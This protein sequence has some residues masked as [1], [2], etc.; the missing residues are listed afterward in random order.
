LE[1]SLVLPD[2]GLQHQQSM[3]IRGS[4]IWFVAISAVLIALVLWFGKKQ[5]VAT[6]AETSVA[7]PA[8]AAPSAPATVPVHTNAPMVQT[9]KGAG[10]SQSPP[11]SKVERAIGILSTYND[12][13]IVFYGRVEDQFTNAV[14]DATVSFNV[15]VMNGQESTVN[16]GQVMTDGNGFFIILGY[17]GQDLGLVPHKPGYVLATTDTLFKYSHLEEHPYV[18]DP[19]NPTVIKMWKLQ[20]AEPLVGIDK[21]Y[22]LRYT[23]EPINFDLLAGQIVPSGGD[24]QITLNRPAGIIS[25]RNPQNW[26]IQI[27]VIDGGFIVTSW[28]EAQTTYSAPESGYESSG[29]F[30]NNN[31]IDTLDQMLF[32]QSR[33]GQVYSKIHLVLGINQ[34]PDG[35][36]YITFKGVA[37]ANGSRNW[38]ATAPQ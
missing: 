24:I 35:F 12:I 1:Y 15:R 26:S 29:T 9:T 21:T 25:G 6:S 28:G 33:N 13:P 37:N 16:R 5:P 14:T 2:T 4:I 27:E 36:M 3:N 8:A 32:V 34:T 38:E 30:G 22:K 18:S 7:P 17:T 23:A 10:L 31:G 19:N 11:M 20:G